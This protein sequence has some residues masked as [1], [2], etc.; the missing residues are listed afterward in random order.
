MKKYY[1]S[2]SKSNE[3]ESSS[4]LYYKIDYNKK[5]FLI[6]RLALHYM[7]IMLWTLET[8]GTDQG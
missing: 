5:L 8:K 1:E 4:H 7:I 2:K 6:T 3:T